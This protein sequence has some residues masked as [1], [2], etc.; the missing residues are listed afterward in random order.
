MHRR[1]L[2]IAALG[3]SACAA[4]PVSGVRRYAGRWDFHF[5]TSSF[6]TSDGEGPWWLSGEGDA[7]PA[8]T[9]PFGEAGSPWGVLDIVVEGELSAPGQYGHLGAYDRELRITRVISTRLVQA[10][11]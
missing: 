1:A 8:L 6:V 10:H 3:V 7:W 5:E 11:R 4:N 9:A 2:L